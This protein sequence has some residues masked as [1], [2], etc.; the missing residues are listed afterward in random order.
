MRLDAIAVVVD[1][2]VQARM[3]DRDVVPLEV[4]VDVDLPIAGELVLFA[5]DVAHR[6]TA[7]SRDAAGDVSEHI[8]ERRCGAVEIHEDERP[9]RRNGDGA[10]AH[11][12]GRESFDAFHLR[13]AKQLALEAVGPSVVLALKR[14][15][16]ATAVR[17][18]ARA[19]K[20]YVVKP[21]Q[22]CLHL[23][24]RRSN[25]FRFPR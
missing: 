21:T 4:V 20:T 11:V 18:R 1:F 23:A 19:V 3:D 25:R 5:H 16:L 22:R 13:R 7:K 2:F 15:S 6:C 17:D 9:P 14:L 24:G 12:G 10:K 8:L